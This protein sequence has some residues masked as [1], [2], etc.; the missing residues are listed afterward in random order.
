MHSPSPTTG[1]AADG[2][3][4]FLSREPVIDRRERLVGYSLRVGQSLDAA[5]GRPPVPGA[6]VA[7]LA[8]AIDAES[9]AA[10]SRNQLAFIRVSRDTL[11]GPHVL[12]LHPRHAVLE[13]ASGLVPDER[14]MAACERLADSGYRF[15]I[16]DFT[17][18]APA[19]PFATMASYL[20][21][22]ASAGSASDRSRAV[23]CFGTTAAV[24]A[25]GVH[26]A[27]ARE[28]AAAEG[29]TCFQGFAVASPPVRRN[30]SGLAPNQ[31]ALMRILRAVN[32]PNMSIGQLEDL[33]KH[34]PALC[35]R[36]LRTINSAAFALRTTVTSVGQ[37]I[38][39][40]GRDT[41]RRWANLWIVAGL[42][43]DG[44]SETV[45]MAAIRGRLCETLA[46]TAR[47]PEA[48]G[49]A[50]LL[51]M[52]SLFEALLGQPV[53][54]VAADLPLGP[55]VRDALVGTPGPMRDLLDCAIAHERG[56]WHESAAL[57]VRARV[58]PRY[59]PGAFMEAV[60]WV[61][62]LDGINMEL[63]TR[64]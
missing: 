13:L 55:E 48:G 31:I 46:S 12:E 26:T 7:R 52:C 21:M 49:E 37:A 28:A 1:R 50:F 24:V 47:G 62:E 39:L 18:D 2:S 8:G 35:Y 15:S 17:V 4:L 61:R 11:L 36:I 14:V 59:L 22:A 29:F 23:A 54:D 38:L 30:S 3:R 10:L 33:V 57:A 9:L 44:H 20:K 25:T 51:G 19:A 6:D 53:D 56:A 16:E 32:N 42:G 41:I 40:L 5:E 45:A 60:R 64:H 43:A 63:S 58:N 27:A 34:D